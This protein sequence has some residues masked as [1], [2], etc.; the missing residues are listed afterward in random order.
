MSV[1]KNIM[2]HFKNRKENELEKQKR[3]DYIQKRVMETGI[4]K[5][6]NRSKEN[7]TRDKQYFLDSN[8]Y[9][10]IFK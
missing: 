6:K 4:E 10:K 3:L 9:G 1:L 8:V 7:N 5:Y 2:E